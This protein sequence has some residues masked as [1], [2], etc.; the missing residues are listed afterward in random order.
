MEDERIVALYF[1]RDEAAIA[2]TKTKYEAYLMKIAYNIL[3]NTEDSSE[4]VN[5]TYLA[6]WNSMPP[7]KPSVL[8]TY[9]G[10]LTRRISIDRVRRR[11]AEKRRGT[12]YAVSLDELSE[13]L[14]APTSP[15][16]EADAKALGEKLSEFLRGLSKEAR[17]AFVSRYFFMDS[18]KE[19]ARYG[20]MSESKAKSLLFRT[21]QSL[22][23]FLRKE[24]YEL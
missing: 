14:P 1:A 13:C 3:F 20:G 23:E 9:L 22:K 5:D 17:V 15:E 24:G 10:K 8:S 21:R 16:Q 18:I 2:E 11:S 7:H 19:I 4:S 12:Q 6:A